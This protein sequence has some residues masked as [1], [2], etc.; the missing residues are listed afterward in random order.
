M[1]KICALALAVLLIF[2]FTGCGSV[3]FESNSM[4]R[5]PKT[6]GDAQEISEA[7]QKTVGRQPFFRYPRS[8]ED[9]KSVV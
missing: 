9:R 5:P 3:M 2:T 8:G 1:K 4:L 7:L 6:S